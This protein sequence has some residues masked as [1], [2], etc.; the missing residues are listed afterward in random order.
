M[1]LVK[2]GCTTKI[3]EHGFEV[4]VNEIHKGTVTLCF[5]L[6]FFDQN[7]H[8]MDEEDVL[9]KGIE[10][11]REKLSDKKDVEESILDMFEQSLVLKDNRTEYDQSKHITN[12]ENFIR[13]GI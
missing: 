5:D 4:H 12:L 9:L 7:P 8:D 1:K 10:I 13:N 3:K 11:I 2:E 6:F